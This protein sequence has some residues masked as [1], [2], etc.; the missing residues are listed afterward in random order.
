MVTR[1]QPGGIERDLE[2]L[3]TINRDHGSCLAVGC[4][5]ATPGTIQ[6]G[7]PLERL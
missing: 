7:D 4:T 1:P 6:L 5:V 3:K 2:V